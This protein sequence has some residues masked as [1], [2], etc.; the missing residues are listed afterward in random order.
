[1]FEAVSR[2]RPNTRRNARLEE[3]I[4]PGMVDRVVELT[5]ISIGSADDWI[6]TRSRDVQPLS[7]SHRNEINNWIIASRSADDLHLRFV[8]GENRGGNDVDDVEDSDDDA[9]SGEMTVNG[10]VQIESEDDDQTEW[11][12]WGEDEILF[13][14][15]TIHVVQTP[16]MMGTEAIYPMTFTEYIN[17]LDLTEPPNHPTCGFCTID[18]FNKNFN[19]RTLDC[20]HVFHDKCLENHFFAYKNRRCPMCNTDIVFHGGEVGY[21]LYFSV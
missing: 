16:E 3:H 18:L 11:S 10:S 20:N 14:T 1:M 4:T 17:S 21:P 12:G 19:V 15:H 7:Q 13:Q 5:S 6:N 8:R 2:L 9:T